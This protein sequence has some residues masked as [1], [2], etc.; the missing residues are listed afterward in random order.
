MDVEVARPADAD[1]LI[2]L[3]DRVARWLEGRGLE[4]WHP[5]ELTAPDLAPWLDAGLVHVVRDPR[6]AIVAAVAVLPDDPVWVHQPSRPAG[7]VHLLMVDRRLAGRGVGAALLSWVEHDLAVREA[8]VARLDVVEGNDH[9][10]RWYGRQG[11]RAVGRWVDP[12]GRWRPS[13]LREKRLLPGRGAAA[14]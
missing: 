14:Q 12:A 6:A 7:Y 1:E 10:Q 8:Q 3:R 2:A 9:L 11:Y 5:G 4:Q 13:V